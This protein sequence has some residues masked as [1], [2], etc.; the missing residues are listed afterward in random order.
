MIPASAYSFGAAALRYAATA[1][2][3]ALVK[4]LEHEIAHLSPAE[5]GRY[6][7]RLL[8]GKK[9]Q[10]KRA[11]VKQALTL[12]LRPGFGGTSSAALAYNVG[13]S[14]MSPRFKS[15]RG[16]YTVS[17]R[18]FITDV[19]GSTTLRVLE[20][21]TQPGV[22]SMFPWLSKIA[23]THQKYKFKKL[24]F[25]YVPIAGA[26]SPGRIT[27]AFATDVLDPPVTDKRQLFQ[28]HNSREGSV[29]SANSIT[30]TKEL[31]GQLFTRIGGV[32]GTDLK[33]YDLG[34][35]IVASSN[36]TDN[37]VIG[38]LFV[39]YEVELSVPAPAQCPSTRYVL[40]SP[41]GSIDQNNLLPNVLPGDHE[42]EGGDWF[43]RKATDDTISIIFRHS[44]N[45]LVNWFFN[46][47]AGS[48]ATISYA[49]LG[50]AVVTNQ[51]IT[52]TSAASR[53]ISA[54]ISIP[55]IQSSTGDD[56][57]VTLVIGGGTFS[58]INTVDIKVSE[59]DLTNTLRVDI[60]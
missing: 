15:A 43:L 12:Q 50:G 45:F 52:P 46:T 36:C 5:I 31:N 49:S 25:S 21:N 28:Y 18:E 17:N 54:V 23:A 30:L 11:A 4:R 27:M 29:W 16:I 39:D 24:N 9:N 40:S 26:S 33:T 6:L 14:G 8:P 35:L 7:Q 38:E 19:R 13:V 51:L 37:S 20:L 32:Q 55:S 1:S 47:T 53:M 48:V 58:N 41:T 56:V 10:R 60:A 42:L 59:F 22:P 57:G 44:G 2:V 34:R 3:S